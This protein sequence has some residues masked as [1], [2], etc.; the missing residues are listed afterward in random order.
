MKV[1]TD[2]D[3]SLNIDTDTGT[4][5]CCKGLTDTDTVFF[6]AITINDTNTCSVL[7]NQTNFILILIQISYPF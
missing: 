3:T 1:L 5:T 6:A 2:T 7:V 4:N